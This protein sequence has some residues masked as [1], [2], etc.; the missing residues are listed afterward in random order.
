MMGWWGISRNRPLSWML[1]RTA[2]HLRVR[3]FRGHGV[4]SP[5][6]YRLVRE[7]FMK[8]RHLHATG[9]LYEA[10]RECRVGK[11]TA[12]MAQAVY[13]YAACNGFAIDSEAECPVQGMYCCLGGDLP[14]RLSGCRVIALF[15]PRASR[16]RYRQCLDAVARH[17]GLSLDCRCILFLFTDSGLSKEHIKL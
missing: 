12:R 13:D 4:H 16:E 9:P 3:H 1:R 17:A 10:L 8:R 7:V 5:F 11:N 15:R 2:V 6:A 14:R